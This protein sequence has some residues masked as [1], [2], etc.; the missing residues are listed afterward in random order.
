MNGERRERRVNEREGLGR[1]ERRRGR[2]GKQRAR[3]RERRKR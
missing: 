3:K 2:V 1:N